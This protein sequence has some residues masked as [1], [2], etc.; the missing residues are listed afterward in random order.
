MLSLFSRIEKWIL[1]SFHS[2]REWKV[3]WKCLKIEIENEKWNENASRSRSEMSTKFSRMLEKRD[4][5]RLL[6]HD[7]H[8][9][10][11][12]LW[13]QFGF[14]TVPKGVSSPGHPIALWPATLTICFFLH[15][16]PSD[17]F[18]ARWWSSSTSPPAQHWQPKHKNQWIFG[19]AW[20]ICWGLRGGGSH[21]PWEGKLV[22]PPRSVSRFLIRCIL[23]PGALGVQYAIRSWSGLGLVGKVTSTTGL[24]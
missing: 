20:H 22:V 1:F 4:S 16:F 8:Y 10:V 19:K 13:G 18:P 15:F 12:N 3:K 11:Q 5:R 9:R 21:L 24:R 7:H 2:F 17:L 23:V 6:D 14:S